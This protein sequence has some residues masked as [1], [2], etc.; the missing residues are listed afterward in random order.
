LRFLYKFFHIC[1]SGTR[2]VN[3]RHICLL[4]LILVAPTRFSAT[5][6][7]AQSVHP[8]LVSFDGAGTATGN[9][10]SGD[11]GAYS[12]SADGRYIVF[13]SDASDL[14][15]NDANGQT[16]VFV[17]DM[18]TGVTRLVSATPTGVSGNSTSWGGSISGNGRYV[19]FTSH[20]SDLILNDTNG[21]AD[22]F[23]RDLQTD[24]T[25]LVSRD[26]TNATGGNAVQRGELRC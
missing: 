3:Y 20:A 9:R 19:L 23:V 26:R 25:R 8:V 18:A 24:T 13:S 6:V 17:R 16:D 4:L 22:V 15:P 10:S 7:K 1:A 12:I 21:A 14:V 2:S 11:L 5:G